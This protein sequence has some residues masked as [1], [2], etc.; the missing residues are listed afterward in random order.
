MI[1]THTVMKIYQHRT[2]LEMSQNQMIFGQAL[3]LFEVQD[4]SALRA[5][6][7][8][9]LLDAVSNLWTVVLPTSSLLAIALTDKPFALKRFTSATTSEFTLLG[10]PHRQPLPV[11]SAASFLAA[12]AVRIRSLVSSL[13]RPAMAPRIARVALPIGV[14]KS[15][16]SLTLIRLTP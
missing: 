16:D 9:T 13:S 2:P 5:P 1:Q 7:L 4:Y 3:T 6:K 15:I 8:F 12:K 14:V 10:R 11:L